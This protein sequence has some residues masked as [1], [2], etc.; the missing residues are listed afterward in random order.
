M[1]YKTNTI[2]LS[3]I[4]FNRFH[5]IKKEKKYYSPGKMFLYRKTSDET[6]VEWLDMIPETAILVD[7]VFKGQNGCYGCGNWLIVN[8]NSSRLMIGQW[9]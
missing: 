3:R 8:E 6:Y 9:N 5:A 4:P 7:F 1:R 2:I